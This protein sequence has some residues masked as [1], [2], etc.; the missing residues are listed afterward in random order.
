MKKLIAVLIALLLVVSFAGCAKSNSYRYAENYRF[1][2]YD[3]VASDEFW[4]ELSVNSSVADIGDL[5]GLIE[6]IAQRDFG[7]LDMDWDNLM[8]IT[9]ARQVAVGIEDMDA[10]SNISYGAQ[11]YY[12]LASTEVGEMYL[13]P[14]YFSAPEKNQLQA[15][16][17]ALMLAALSTAPGE[18]SQLNE[19]LAEYYTSMFMD[20]V[21]YTMEETIYPHQMTAAIWLIT[22]FGEDAVVNAARENKLEELIDT[23]TKPGMGAKLEEALNAINLGGD[24]NRAENAVYDI[25]AHTTLGAGKKLED[26][27]YL[28]EYVKDL[29]KLEGTRV[30]SSYVKKVLQGRA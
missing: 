30:D 17:H 29:S 19:G 24:P 23:Y 22:V 5:L 28:V 21:G 13:F 6:R 8:N 12:A 1:T 27:D 25:L 11:Y 10:P 9:T 15:L 16:T 7:K 4:T 3:D 18:S 26:V 2:A 14:G 20:N